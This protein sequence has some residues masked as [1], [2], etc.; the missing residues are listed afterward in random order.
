MREHGH[1]S[2]GDSLSSVSLCARAPPPLVRQSHLHL[3]DTG[4]LEHAE[5]RARGLTE[6]STGKTRTHFNS[7][8]RHRLPVQARALRPRP[9]V[10]SHQ[11]LGFF[12]D[13]MAKSGNLFF[14][15]G[16]ILE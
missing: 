1:L 14:Q 11:L 4:T 9:Q 10:L 2:T 3:R 8:S 16:L 7:G 12:S 6:P 15:A 13:N 5:P